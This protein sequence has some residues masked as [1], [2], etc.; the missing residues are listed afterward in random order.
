MSVPACELI[1]IFTSHSRPTY[2]SCLQLSW[3]AGND[4][5]MALK[6]FPCKTLHW[7]IE[8]ML[9]ELSRENGDGASNKKLQKCK[10]L[11][12]KA[13]SE[14]LEEEQE[15]N[16]KNLKLC[17]EIARVIVGRDPVVYQHNLKN[18]HIWDYYREHMKRD[19]SRSRSRSRSR[20]SK[21]ASLRGKGSSRSA[22]LKRKGSGRSTSLKSMPSSESRRKKGSDTR[23]NSSRSKSRSESRNRSRR[24]R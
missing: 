24:R 1:S 12:A 3:A 2:L 14:P 22:S 9:K 15:N 11:A 13:H 23:R 5:G 4:S 7:A 19:K 21:S 17:R 10:K 16:C 20:S 8:A 18:G 6:K